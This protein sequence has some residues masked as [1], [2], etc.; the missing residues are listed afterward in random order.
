MSKSIKFIDPFG[1]INFTEALPSVQHK[2]I[3]LR[4]WQEKREDGH[5]ITLEAAELLKEELEQIIKDMKCK[6]NL[7]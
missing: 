5:F 6:L 3:V 4:F 1:R 2:G 7:S